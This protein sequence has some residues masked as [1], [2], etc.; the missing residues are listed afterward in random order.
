MVYI[1]LPQSTAQVLG[2]YGWSPPVSLSSL[3]S[4][5][6]ILK[7][8]TGALNAQALSLEFGSGGG[9]IVRMVP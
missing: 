9:W 4:G 8:L 6:Q 3:H 1:H 5:T 7:H 2:S